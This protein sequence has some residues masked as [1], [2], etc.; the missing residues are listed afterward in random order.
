MKFGY[1]FG[2][3]VVDEVFCERVIFCEIAVEVEEFFEVGFL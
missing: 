1:L 2:L 3:D